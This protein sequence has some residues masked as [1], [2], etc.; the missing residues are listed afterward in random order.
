MMGN[1][2]NL[3]LNQWFEIAKIV[4]N[5]YI[6]SH[7][8]FKAKRSMSGVWHLSTDRCDSASLIK[9]YDNAGNGELSLVERLGPDTEGWQEVTEITFDKI[10]KYIEDATERTDSKP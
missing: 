1:I 5:D 8:S 9:V 2:H 6:G 10:V 3:T 4:D 7:S